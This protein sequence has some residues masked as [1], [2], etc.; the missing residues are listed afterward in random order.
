M[1]LL[2]WIVFW[3][4]LALV[5]AAM[6]VPI[7]VLAWWAGWSRRTEAKENDPAPSAP[8]TPAAP[9]LGPFLVYLS[10]VGDI[11]DE[12]QTTYE[13]ALLAEIAAQVPGLVITSDVFAFSVENLS[14]TSERQLG[15]FWAW[16]NKE[17]LFMIWRTVPRPRSLARYSSAR[18]IMERIESAPMNS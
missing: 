2:L 10:G 14:M 18:L 17:R 15:W 12:Y 1:S 3:L 13:D 6:V 8:V 11:S 7:T 9:A 16:V 4:L 5:V